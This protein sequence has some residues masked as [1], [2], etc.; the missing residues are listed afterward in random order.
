[1]ALPEAAAQTMLAAREAAVAKA[2]AAGLLGAASQRLSIASE[3]TGPQ[4]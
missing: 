2:E 4:F 3:S 1:L